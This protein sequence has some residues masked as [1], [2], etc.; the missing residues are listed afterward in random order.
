MTVLAVDTRAIYDRV[1]AVYVPIAI[2]VFVVVVGTTLLLVWRGRRR[3]AAAGPPEARRAEIAY[4][5][6]LAIVA[7]IL[8]VITFHAQGR[9]EAAAARTGVDVRAI[10]A[11]WNWRF[12]YPRLGVRVAGRPGAPATLT[13]PAGQEVRFSATSL[14]VTHG[15]W[16]PSAKF[17]RELFPGRDV[18]FALR[19]PRPGYTT[20]AACSFFCGLGHADMRFVL[21]VLPAG[22]FR[23]W[24]ARARAGG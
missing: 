9:I 12:E 13:V 16:L 20:N 11:K 3:E 7:G 23:A 4:G 6:A 8:V 15:F 21:R 1:A 19:F 18:H 10:A 2:A 14:D 22:E 24:A 17:Q 5:V